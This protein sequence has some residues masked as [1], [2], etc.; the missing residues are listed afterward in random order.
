MAGILF[1]SPGIAKTGLIHL[2][3]AYSIGK[4]YGLAAFGVVPEVFSG[5]IG[6]GNAVRT[7]STQLDALF[8]VKSL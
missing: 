5:R 2:S 8:R 1:L 7:H 3:L 4:S 6:T